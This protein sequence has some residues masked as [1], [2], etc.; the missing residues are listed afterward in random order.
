VLR[1]PKWCIRRERGQGLR[2][3]RQYQF[4]EEIDMSALP[5]SGIKI[6]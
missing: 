2:P 4:P 6:L 1:T 3:P 5:L